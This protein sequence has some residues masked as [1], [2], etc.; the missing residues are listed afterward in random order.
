VETKK[1]LK[2]L[3]FQF[4]RFLRRDWGGF[5]LPFLFLVLV[6]LLILIGCSTPMVEVG[7]V[8]VVI[9]EPI[10]ATHNGEG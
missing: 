8:T 3:M 9:Q 2:R 7:K 4:D 6:L 1:E 10:K 5:G